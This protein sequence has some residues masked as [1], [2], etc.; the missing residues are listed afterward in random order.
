MEDNKSVLSNDEVRLVVEKRQKWQEAFVLRLA[1]LRS[2]HLGR[3]CEV[4]ERV[5]P[6]AGGDGE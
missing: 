6:H 1:V 2:H 5:E 3:L 4:L